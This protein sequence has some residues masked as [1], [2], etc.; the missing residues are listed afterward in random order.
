MGDQGRTVLVLS[1]GASRGAAQIGMLRALLERGVVPDHLV[2]T[3]VGAL[4]AAFLACDPT[5]ARVA[6]LHE[7]W[8]DISGGTIFPGTTFTRLRHLARR[9]PYLYDNANLARVV[10]D[11]VPHGRLEDLPTPVRV[12]TSELGSGLPSYHDR[13]DVQ[14]LLLASTALPAV[15]P[16]VVLTN[17][18]TGE[19]SLHVDGGI[20]DNVPLAGAVDL[21]P[22]TVYVLNVSPPVRARAPRNPIDVLIMSLGASM[23][24]RPTVDLGPSVRVVE[25]GFPELDVPM[26]DFSQTDALV[27][28]GHAAAEAVL[29]AHAAA[30]EVP[31]LRLLAGRRRRSR[32]EVA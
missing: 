18:V 28:A 27:D 30:A 10:A 22:T 6:E 15:F 32:A 14:E 2:G 31:R 13:G 21:A 12:V 5:P 8:R 7:G 4:N 19:E 11:W 9:R 23:R 16:P 24:L 20:T 25:I 3:S 1:G 17:P 29:D 26:T